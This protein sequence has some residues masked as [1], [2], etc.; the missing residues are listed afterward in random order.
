VLFESAVRCLYRHG[1]GGTT[2]INVAREAGVSRGAMLHQFPSKADLM[3]FVVEEA[4]A[5]E[6]ELYR[7][8]LR[9]VDRPRERLIAYPAAAWK[10]LSR[11]AAVAVLEILQGS[12]SDGELNEK[13]SPILERIE[14]AAHAQLSREF[15]RGPSPALRQLIVGAVR[16]LA[17][18]SV[19][20]PD[21]EGMR[22]AIPLLQDLV[23]SG[24]ETGVFGL[25]PAD[26]DP[27]GGGLAPAR[28][29]GSRSAIKAAPS[30]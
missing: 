7:Q 12:R 15:P 11:P 18:M 17:M 14:A 28:K 21:D 5:E 25:R 23:R 2:T 1:Y 3:V 9:G 24:L 19:L 16:G 30:A 4:F 13:L 22:G 29:A 26:P 27:A 10:A 6:V 20:D 8:L